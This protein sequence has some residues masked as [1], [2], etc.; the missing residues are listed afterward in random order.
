MHQ[1][2]KFI[3]SFGSSATTALGYD[4]LFV[5]SL[6]TVSYVNDTKHTTSSPSLYHYHLSDTLT[7][8]IFSC[9]LLLAYIFLA[10]STLKTKQILRSFRGLFSLVWF[11]TS[12]V[13][14][15]NCPNLNK[16]SLMNA[17]GR[18]TARQKTPKTLNS[19]NA[20]KKLCWSLQRSIRCHKFCLQ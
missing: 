3:K 17:I 6:V 18:I 16:D 19:D 1:G 7:K 20:K 4:K 8:I 9:S 2:Q 13:H 5:E 12:A 15:E 11:A 14:F 10:P